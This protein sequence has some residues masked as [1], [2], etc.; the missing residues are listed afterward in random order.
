[1][2][3]VDDKPTR[4]CTFNIF[5]P[6]DFLSYVLDKFN[7]NDFHVNSVYSRAGLPGLDSGPL[8]IILLS[9]QELACLCTGSGSVAH[10][11]FRFPR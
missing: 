6:L 7:R 4:F 11:M 9:E 2:L 1:M 8:G 10:L 5:K 3:Q